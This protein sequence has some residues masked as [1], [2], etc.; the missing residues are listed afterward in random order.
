MVGTSP[1]TG[2]LD[3]SV[4]GRSF[5]NTLGSVGTITYAGRTK[6]N[7]VFSLSIDIDGDRVRFFGDRRKVSNILTLLG[8]EIAPD[9]LW[10]G[11]KLDLPCQVTLKDSADGAYTN[12]DRVFPPREPGADG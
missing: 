2:W 4:N 12:A 5:T 11:V 3:K 1:V 8:E 7:K 10:E 9:D 6:N